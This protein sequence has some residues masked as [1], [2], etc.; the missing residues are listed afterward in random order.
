MESWLPS[1][2]ALHTLKNSTE[3]KCSERTKY[4]HTAEQR[5]Q[6][7]TKRSK[8]EHTAVVRQVSKYKKSEFYFYSHQNHKFASEH[9]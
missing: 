9:F 5:Q 2:V 7:L 1:L 8:H 6:S 3:N 4:R